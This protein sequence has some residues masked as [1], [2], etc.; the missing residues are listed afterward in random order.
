MGGNKGR[1]AMII[2]LLLMGGTIVWYI[3]LAD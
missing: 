1:I 3:A 2:Y